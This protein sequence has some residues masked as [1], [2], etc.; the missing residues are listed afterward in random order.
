MGGDGGQ[1]DGHRVRDGRELRSFWDKG[2]PSPLC[3]AAKRGATQTHGTG[4]VKSLVGQGLQTFQPVTPKVTVPETGDPHQ[5][6]K[7]HI[8]FAQHANALSSLHRHVT[9]NLYNNGLNMQL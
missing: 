6:L 8:M 1:Q 9:K 2:C 3:P 7:C 4:G 5:P